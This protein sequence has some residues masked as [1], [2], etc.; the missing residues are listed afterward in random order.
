MPRD[1]C[2]RSAEAYSP[3]ASS[4]GNYLKLSLSVVSQTRNG[5]ELKTKRRLDS[6][7]IPCIRVER[8]II[9]YTSDEDN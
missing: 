3:E 2:V 9:G 8:L 4:Y 1:V 6:H 5:H 7:G